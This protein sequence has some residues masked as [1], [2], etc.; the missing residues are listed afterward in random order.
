MSTPT[1]HHDARVI[2]LRGAERPAPPAAAFRRA[3]LE[4]LDLVVPDSLSDELLLELAR[5]LKTEGA[6]LICELEP[7]RRAVL[8]EGIDLPLVD[9]ALAPLIL[10]SA[11]ALVALRARGVELEAARFALGGGAAARVGDVLT[12]LGLPVSQRSTV[13]SLREGPPAGVDVFLLPEANL[14]GLEEDPVGP[15]L[16]GLVQHEDEGILPALARAA[17]DSGRT[18]TAESC[19]GVAR[20]LVE[21]AGPSHELPALDDPSLLDVVAPAAVAACWTGEGSDPIEAGVYRDG[22]TQLRSPLRQAL[23][24]AVARARKTPRKLV[25]LDAEEPAMLL[26]ARRLLEEGLAEPVLLGVLFRLESSAKGLGVSLRG[27]K[28]HNPRRDKLRAPYAEALAKTLGPRLGLDLDEA[29][30]WVEQPSVF[31]ALTVLRGD[32]HGL[33]GLI[34][35]D[36]R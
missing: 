26:A 1:P 24:E 12:A 33:V 13:D 18:L 30:R 17:A 4:L 2:L 27:M 19:G 22:L 7:R 36:R 9:A 3:G 14:A 21:R 29:R 16:V 34:R 20:A 32:A 6:A 31:G 28:L 8:D 15:A 25:F 10:N 23:S 11:R 5:S 35:R